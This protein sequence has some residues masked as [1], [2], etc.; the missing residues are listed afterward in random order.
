MKTTGQGR[1]LPDLERLFQRGTASSSDRALLVAFATEGDEAAFE[2]LVNRHGP[3]VRGV[4]RRFLPN[5]HD[6]DDAFQATFLVLARKAGRIRD[7]DRLAPWL[8]GVAFRVATKARTQA[9]RRRDRQPIADDMAGPDDPSAEWS[10]VGPI[11]DAELNRLRSKHRDV[12][13]L[14]LIEGATAE[15]ASARLGCP[16]GTVKSRL[17]RARETLRARLTSRGVAP[18]AALALVASSNALAS[19]VPST[20]TRATLQTITAKVVPPGV[21]ALATGAASTMFWKSTFAALALV[22]SVGLSAAYWSEPPAREQPPAKGEAQAG[23]TE[24][25]PS[26][27]INNLK[28]ILVALQVFE[29]AQG[30]FPPA[31]IHGVDGRPKLSW[32][33]ALLPYLDQKELYQQFRLNESWDSPHNKTLIDRMPAVFETPEAPTPKGQTRFRGFAANGTMFDPAYTRILTGPGTERRNL[34]IPTISDG[35]SNTA[36]I[37]IARDAT[38]WT[39]PGELSVQGQDVPAL[40]ES[41]PRGI[42]LGMVD[43]AALHL[44]P[45]LLQR[46]LGA[47][48]TKSGGE[49][50]DRSIFANSQRPNDQTSSERFMPT[51]PQT[52]HAH[53]HGGATTQYHR[54]EARPPTSQARSRP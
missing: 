45:E 22:G 38:P 25:K 48:A 28:R 34:E 35:L 1:L 11:I 44:K 24:A 43:G 3:L 20:L 16:V 47:L 4:C 26:A 23:E 31:A 40:D 10:D 18:A 13:I 50:I 42:V 12:L 39:K 21:A 41:D 2:T 51:A 27:N 9:A 49:I 46:W 33:V 19:P 5:T 14:C 17:A 36:Y 8:Y 53:A 29:S 7:P 15:E 37:A 54:R 32:R 30:G 52:A 6:A